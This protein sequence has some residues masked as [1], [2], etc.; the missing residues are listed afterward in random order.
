MQFIWPNVA[1]VSIFWT[2]LHKNPRIFHISQVSVAHEHTGPI[3]AMYE[4]IM[5]TWN[6]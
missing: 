4:V 5:I 2:T 3:G 6:R 1:A